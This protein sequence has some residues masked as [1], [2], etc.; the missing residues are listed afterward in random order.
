M[1][2]IKRLRRSGGDGGQNVGSLAATSVRNR[3]HSIDDTLSAISPDF[4]EDLGRPTGLQNGPF[5]WLITAKGCRNMG[6]ITGPVGGV[7]N[8]AQKRDLY[9]RLAFE[10][11][12]HVA[13]IDC[14]RFHRIPGKSSTPNE[15]PKWPFYVIADKGY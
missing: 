12:P 3:D 6:K 1:G 14:P 8:G 2:K 13:M 11:G 4:E 10:M 5:S 15:P 9:L 7:G